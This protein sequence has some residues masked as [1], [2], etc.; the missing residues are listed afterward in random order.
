MGKSTIS[1]ATFNSFLYVYQRVFH[2]KNEFSPYH[3][4]F[5]NQPCPWLFYVA[6][7]RPSGEVM[8]S[9]DR[10]GMTTG[11]TGVTGDMV[12]GTRC[13]KGY[14]LVICYIAIENGH[15]YWIFPLKMVIFY[16]YVS[17]PEGRWSSNSSLWSVAFRIFL[18]FFVFFVVVL[19]VSNYGA[20]EFRCSQRIMGHYTILC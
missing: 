20:L 12:H 8:L 5:F 3:G 9:F 16:S 17:L 18:F 10:P 2:V 1:M 11:E 19:F 7:V 6:A 15:L 4:W 14:T 13:R